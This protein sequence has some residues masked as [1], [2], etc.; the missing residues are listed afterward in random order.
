M[1]KYLKVVE[2]DDCLYTHMNCLLQIEDVVLVED[3]DKFNKV[4]DN[5]IIDVNQ[6]GNISLFE[7]S[8]FCG[9]SDIKTIVGRS[10]V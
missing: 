7:F 6:N 8:I 10:Q 5:Y 9:N 4:L 2:L 3:V 1:G